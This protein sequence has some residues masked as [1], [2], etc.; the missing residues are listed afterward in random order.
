MNNKPPNYSHQTTQQEMEAALAA[1]RS[2]YSPALITLALYWILFWIGGLLANI[3]YLNSAYNTKRISG[4]SP[5]G[6]GCLWALILFHVALPLCAL[7]SFG[8]FGLC[9]SFG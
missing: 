4:K 3:V 9:F 2:Y 7:L 5:E 8:G 1:S 6:L